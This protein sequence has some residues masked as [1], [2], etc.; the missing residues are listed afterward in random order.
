MGIERS[1]IENFSQHIRDLKFCV[2]DFTSQ[3]IFLNVFLSEFNIF[4]KKFD[5]FYNRYEYT[6]SSFSKSVIKL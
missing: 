1:F 2:D 4:Y 5:Q 3:D 6:F